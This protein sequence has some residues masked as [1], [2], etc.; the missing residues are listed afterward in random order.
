ML[1]FVEE[2]RI[3]FQ[4]NREIRTNAPFGTFYLCADDAKFIREY[5]QTPHFAQKHARA[6]TPQTAGRGNGAFF[7]R[8]AAQNDIYNASYRSIIERN[9]YH[10]REALT[11][12]LQK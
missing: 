1:I 10:G 9:E 11:C 6:R 3:S 12:T 8:Y 4:R 5:A 7:A 2:N